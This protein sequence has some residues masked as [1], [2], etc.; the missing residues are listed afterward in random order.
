MPPAPID[1]TPDIS[2]AEIGPVGRPAHI[3]LSEIGPV[4]PEPD[5]PD[6]LIEEARL[7]APD[8]RFAAMPRDIVMEGRHGVNVKPQPSDYRAPP[9]TTPREIISMRDVSPAPSEE[10]ILEQ[11]KGDYRP[12]ERPTGMPDRELELRDFN[13]DLLK[14]TSR[15]AAGIGQTQG[16]TL[17][18]GI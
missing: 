1:Y 4:G 8:I 16:R 14:G 13:L 9:V 11:I 2:L 12:T 3:S 6:W 15:Y 7:K 5:L 17:G 18:E 10:F